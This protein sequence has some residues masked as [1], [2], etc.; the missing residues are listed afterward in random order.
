ML[1][2]MFTVTEDEDAAFGAACEQRGE[3]AAAVELRY[4]AGHVGLDGGPP[5]APTDGDEKEAPGLTGAAGLPTPV[6]YG[7][8]YTTLCSASQDG[9]SPPG[10]HPSL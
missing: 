8:A 2:G 6:G 10:L 4:H 9:S 5:D 3:L 7:A 1:S